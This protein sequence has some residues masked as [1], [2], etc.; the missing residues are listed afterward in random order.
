[1]AEQQIIEKELSHRIMA[2]AFEVHNKL[3]PGYPEKIYDEA[4]DREL[5]L[6]GVTVESQKRIL[7][8]YNEKPLGEFI[9]D[10]VADERV[11]LEIKAVSQILPIH[12]QQA[13]SY[14][15]ATGLQLAIV[16]NFGAARVQSSRVVLTRGKAF[17]PPQLP[18]VREPPLKE[19]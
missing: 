4:L 10:K 18:E 14:L 2:A 15:K 9:L 13:L 6:H 1:M 7:V 17:V 5:P 8:K 19:E 3:G 16:I 12:K 11:I